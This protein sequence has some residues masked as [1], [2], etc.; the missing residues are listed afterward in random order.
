[1]P[2]MSAIQMHTV[3]PSVKKRLCSAEAK[4]SVLA[5]K[6]QGE[7]VAKCR[8]SLTQTWIIIAI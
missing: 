2:E 8:E 1:M 7:G 6:K 5:F 4:G 3:V